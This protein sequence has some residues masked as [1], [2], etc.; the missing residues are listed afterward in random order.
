MA[1]STSKNKNIVYVANLNDSNVSIIGSTIDGFTATNTT[2]QSGSIGTAV[3]AVTQAPNDNSTAVATTE[4]VDTAIGAYNPSQT[5][6]AGESIA[7]DELVY[8]ET[9]GKV[10]LTSAVGS[11]SEAAIIGMSTETVIAD[12]PV[13][14][15]TTGVFT[16]LTGLTAGSTYYLSGSVDGEMSDTAP[17]SSGDHIVKVG[18][19]VSSTTLLF[20]PQF[21]YTKG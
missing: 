12:D 19:A 7:T 18:I 21:I 11:I 10:W 4:Y 16:G 14:V 5:F 2:F 15:Q 1:K 6:T 3:V 13:I 20:Q 9:D 17:S 8:I